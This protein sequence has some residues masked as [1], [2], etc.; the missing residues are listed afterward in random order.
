MGW[1]LVRPVRLMQP[2]NSTYRNPQK[3]PGL[4]PLRIR[5]NGQ[6]GQ[7]RPLPFEENTMQNVPTPNTSFQWMINANVNASDLEWLKRM[8]GSVELHA[9]NNRERVQRI[10]TDAVAG[11]L[12]KAPTVADLIKS[13]N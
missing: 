7:S 9:T 8:E 5:L 13:L 6:K 3:R 4:S 10:Y 11:L 2:E 12:S 1:T